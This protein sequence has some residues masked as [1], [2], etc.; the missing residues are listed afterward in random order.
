MIA[1]R[2]SH[3]WR[4]FGSNAIGA[5]FGL[6]LLAGLGCSDAWAEP[7]DLTCWRGAVEAYTGDPDSQAGA[8]IDLAKGDTEEVPPIAL[9]AVADAHLRS[10][11]RRAADRVLADVLARDPGEPERSWAVAGRAWVAMQRRDVRGA[12]RLLVDH[13]GEDPVGLPA[14]ALGMLEASHGDRRTGIEILASVAEHEQ[15]PRSLRLAAEMGT[16]LA[17]YWAG[18]FDEAIAV[19]DG[20]ADR[21][22]A[23][24][25]QDEARYAAARARLDA[26]DSVG[27]NHDLEALAA[28]A[29]AASPES[30]RR[31]PWS[32]ISPRAVL[33]AGGALY[34]GPGRGVP[35]PS[36]LALDLFEWDGRALAARFLAERESTP[37][38]IRVADARIAPSSSE[39]AR[40]G[41]RS[42]LGTTSSRV[43]HSP[44]DV[45]PRRGH[46]EPAS[47]A[48]WV[49]LV[50][51][52]LATLAGLGWFVRPI[53]VR[54]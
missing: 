39:P 6:G 14:F 38:A 5:C 27:A 16:G 1:L 25:L 43:E 15:T 49:L 51:G 3:V 13:V 29:S 22:E 7:C 53:G 32:E 18:S 17:H 34:R 50:G 19:F 41:P 26:G 44:A 20:I 54:R 10:G 11:H 48:P 33:G 23:Y 42:V 21:P 2:S 30:G 40:L 52:V 24:R 36:E 47:S 31:R 45:E 8:L 46:A 28:T 4:G 35:I 37:T 12:R 9:L